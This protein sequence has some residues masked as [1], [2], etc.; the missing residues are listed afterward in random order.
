MP[1]ASLAQGG[2]LISSIS[3]HFEL[4]LLTGTWHFGPNFP[5]NSSGNAANTS[6]NITFKFN[7]SAVNVFA[8]LQRE[9]G[10]CWTSDEIFLTHALSRF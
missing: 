10:I 3:A 6:A 1:N 9:V 7:G 4:I 8:I 2:K 5:T